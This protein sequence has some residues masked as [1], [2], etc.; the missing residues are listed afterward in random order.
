MEMPILIHP[1]IAAYYSMLTPWVHAYLS[2][3]SF[4]GMFP[5]AAQTLSSWGFKM[6]VHPCLYPCYLVL[7]YTLLHGPIVPGDNTFLG[8]LLMRI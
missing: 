7:D 4:G 2:S 6:V 5:L 8:L 3:F 1:V